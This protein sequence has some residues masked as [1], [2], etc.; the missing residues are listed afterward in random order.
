MS[1]SQISLSCYRGKT[2]QDA[3][4]E[5]D[6]RLLGMLNII[7]DKIHSFNEIWIIGFYD[8]KNTEKSNIIIMLKLA[9]EQMHMK[10]HELYFNDVNDIDMNNK[11][12]LY[13]YNS[14]AYVLNDFKN[15]NEDNYL[16]TI[17]YSFMDPGH[18]VIIPIL[19]GFERY[20]I[21]NDS[22]YE[23]DGIV[24]PIREFTV[25]ELAKELKKKLE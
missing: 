9:C 4:R 16:I 23:Y 18:Y 24:Y 13:I 25:D 1:R 3:K 2:I 12:I 10:Y 7:I 11:S 5:F 6:L 17:K 15:V 20:Q 8:D 19:K 14:H 21:Y 22:E